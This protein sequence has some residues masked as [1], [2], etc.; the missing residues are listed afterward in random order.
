MNKLTT[1]A[2][3]ALN[4]VPP[5][6]GLKVVDKVFDRPLNNPLF[7]NLRMGGYTTRK[8]QRGVKVDHGI[9]HRGDIWNA[10]DQPVLL[11]IDSGCLTSAVFHDE[12]CDCHWQLM[13]AMKLINDAPE[14]TLGLII[15]HFHH[16]GKA[17]GFTAKLKSYRD[18]MYPVPGDKRQFGSSLLILKD[19]GIKRV[20]VM[21]NNPEKLAVLVDNGI[22]VVEVIHLVTNDPKLRW[23]LNYKAQTFGHQIVFGDEPQSTGEAALLQASSYPPEPAGS[24]SRE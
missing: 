20:R 3:P 2:S 10:G 17:H 16:E 1:E 15:E 22:E 12:S 14:G 5:Q 23:F 7:P 18:G 4:G 19:L 24:D 6:T 13:Q 11:R 8:G 9:I 21:T